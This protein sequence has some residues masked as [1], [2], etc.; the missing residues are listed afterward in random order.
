MTETPVSYTHLDVYK[1]KLQRWT[2]AAL[3]RAANKQDG[4]RGVSRETIRR[5]LTKTSLNLGASP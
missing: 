4:L 1:R 3:V 2:I 5:I